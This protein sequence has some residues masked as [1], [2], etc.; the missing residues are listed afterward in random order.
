MASG[1]GFRIIGRR[2]EPSG[3]ISYQIEWE[4]NGDI[5]FWIRVQHFSF[6]EL[7]FGASTS[8]KIYLFFKL[9]FEFEFSS[10]LNWIFLS[11]WLTKL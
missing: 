9:V 5:D 4:Q 7:K 8:H 1:E 2:R 10:L 6:I 3:R 11:I